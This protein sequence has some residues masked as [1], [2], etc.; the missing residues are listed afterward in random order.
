MTIVTTGDAAILEQI[1]KQLRKLIDVISVKNL[2]GSHF[3]EREMALIKIRTE[4]PEKQSRLLQLIEIFD[5]TI[6]SVSREEIGVEIAAVPIVSTTSSKWYA[7]SGS[8]KW[9]VPAASP[10]AVVGKTEFASRQFRD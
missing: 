4:S 7:T 10:S 9:P 6:V 5:G 2:T 3:V 8:W 1:D